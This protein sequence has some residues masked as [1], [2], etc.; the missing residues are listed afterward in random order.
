MTSRIV[1]NDDNGIINKMMHIL[2]TSTEV[3][4][5]IFRRGVTFGNS[6]MDNS[7]IFNTD[8]AFNFAVFLFDR[9]D[10]KST[11]FLIEFRYG[12]FLQMISICS[13]LWISFRLNTLHF[14][15]SHSL[16]WDCIFVRIYPIYFS[17][18]K[19]FIR[20]SC[21]LCCEISVKLFGSKNARLSKHLK[22][23]F[24]IDGRQNCD[25]KKIL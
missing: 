18:L 1:I 25:W 16:K 22:K 9:E 17:Q 7:S 4:C 8:I 24:E 11:R 20:V 15:F 23:M 5:Y 13:F 2:H 21:R 14:S 3:W 12:F 10:I 19:T 6:G